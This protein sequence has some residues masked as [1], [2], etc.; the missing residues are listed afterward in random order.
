LLDELRLVAGAYVRAREGAL[1]RFLALEEGRRQTRVNEAMA[2]DASDAFRLERDLI[3]PGDVHRWMAENQIAR[4]EYDRLM[5]EEALRLRWE[6]SLEDELPALLFDWLRLQGHYPALLARALDKKQRLR[7]AG[8]ENPALADVGLSEPELLRWFFKECGAA[9]P[10]DLARFASGLGY[11][12]EE[13]YRLVLLCEYCYRR[14][15]AAPPPWDR[16]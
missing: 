4:D 5:Q 8:L 3:E 13:N 1:L 6:R 14:L 11:A 7:Q 2:R 12:D 10:P 9:V 16:P 15:G